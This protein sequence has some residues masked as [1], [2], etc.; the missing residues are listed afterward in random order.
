MLKKKYTMIILILLLLLALSSM[1]MF[2]FLDGNYAVMGKQLASWN[3]IY[4]IG[5]PRSWDECDPASTN[6]LVAAQTD[7]AEMY[8]MLSLDTYNYGPDATLDSFVSGYMSSLGL[9]SDD[10][11]GSTMVTLEEHKIAGSINGYYYEYTAVSH[12]IPVRMFCYA[13][14]V[15]EGFLTI[16][17]AAGEAVADEK[18]ETAKAIIDSLRI[19]KDTAQ[20]AAAAPSAESEAE[21]PPEEAPAEDEAAEDTEETEEEEPTGGTDAL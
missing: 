4:T 6:G 1:L 18:R 21:A 16:D 8:A 17:V 2:Q 11:A 14:Q 3:N 10:P 7:D 20:Q 9:H 12:G 13:T 15:E 5:V 19:H